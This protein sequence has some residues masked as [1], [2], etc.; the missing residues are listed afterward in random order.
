[1]EDQVVFLADEVNE[2]SVVVRRSSTD[3]C[4][5]AKPQAG[6][7]QIRMDRLSARRVW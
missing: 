6:A 7:A 5:L 4:E 2:A 3:C 1:M